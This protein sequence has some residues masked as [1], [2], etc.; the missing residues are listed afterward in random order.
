MT[1]MMMMMME[2]RSVE[3]IRRRE[4]VTRWQCG[5]SSKFFD[6]LSIARYTERESVVPW[7]LTI[8]SPASYIHAIQPRD[9]LSWSH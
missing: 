1:M 3:S 8:V 4:G 9:Q 5:F 7:Q 6:R 2:L